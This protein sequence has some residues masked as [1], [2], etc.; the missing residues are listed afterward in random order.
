VQHGRVPDTGANRLA[1]GRADKH[2]DELANRHADGIAN[3]GANG[4]PDAST[5]RLPCVCVRAVVELQRAMRWRRAEALAQRR[6]DERA[7]R[8]G[9]WRARR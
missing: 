3:K 7:W 5:H 4:P 1:Y 9:L 6:D 8:R 2:A